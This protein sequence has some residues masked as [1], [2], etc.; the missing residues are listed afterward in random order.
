M[1]DFVKTGEVITMSHSCNNCGSLFV[2]YQLLELSP[3]VTDIY[4]WCPVCKIEAMADVL[5]DAIK[6]FDKS[7]IKIKKMNI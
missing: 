6:K 1:K 5:M 4:L 2:E 3:G 7:A